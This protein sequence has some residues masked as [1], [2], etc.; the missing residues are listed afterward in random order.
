[1]MKSNTNQGEGTNLFAN[2]GSVLL[3]NLFSLDSKQIRVFSKDLA[4]EQ[5]HQNPFEAASFN[6]DYK[7]V[8]GQASDHQ[9]RRNDWSLKAGRMIYDRWLLEIASCG[10]SLLVLI[11]IVV[12]LYNYDGAEQPDW[13]YNITINSVISWF[14]TIMKAL[15]FVS[16]AS[17]LSQA[18]WVHFTKSPHPFKDYL[19]YDSASRGF[20][21]SLQLLFSRQ[22]GY[23]TIS[24]ARI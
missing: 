12:F 6:N 9:Y 17:C 14:T 20:Y 24:A 4:P 19:V 21:G 1:M 18:N 11:A 22:V 15:M 2:A 10:G 7:P 8:E 23:V 13:P 16:V 5:H 3:R